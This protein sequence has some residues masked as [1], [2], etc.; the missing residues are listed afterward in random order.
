[1]GLSLWFYFSSFPSS[2]DFC[3]PHAAALLLLSCI[4][5]C[6]PPPQRGSSQ[7]DSV[8]TS[9]GLR[10]HSVGGLCLKKNL[11]TEKIFIWILTLCMGLGD[12]VP[13]LQ[14]LLAGG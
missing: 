9:Y 4:V 1:M 8:E 3:G 11:Q 5:L 6:L 2:P 13:V 10:T 7:L 14:S 12:G